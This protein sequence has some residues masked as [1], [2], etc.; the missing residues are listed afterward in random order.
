MFS[1][2]ISRTYNLLL[3]DFN[4]LE[5]YYNVLGKLLAEIKSIIEQRK[6]TTTG[7]WGSSR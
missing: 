2:I 5:K 3:I 7:P 6:P 4:L 1:K